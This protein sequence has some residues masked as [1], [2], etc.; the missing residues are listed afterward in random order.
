MFGNRKDLSGDESARFALAVALRDVAFFR[1]F[2]PG[3]LER[4][5][6]L[7]EEVEADPGVVIIDQGRV[8]RECF[9][10]LEGEAT[11]LVG[12]D[13]VATIGTGSM[14]GEMA[15]VEHRP[16]SASVVADTPMRLVAF[17]TDAFRQ[18]LAEMPKA[19]D[20]VITTLGARLE[21]NARRSAAGNDAA[22]SDAAES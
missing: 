18:L 4:V 14:I 2:E 8:G 17:D 3:E 12:D 9:V 6:A 15:L 21:A 16:R 1:G 7:A 20:R 13:V 22:G 5:A 11:V 19:H 10:V